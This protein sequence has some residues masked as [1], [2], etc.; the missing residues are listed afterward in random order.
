MAEEQELVQEEEVED[1]E[2][3][4]EAAWDQHEAEATEAVEE[5]AQQESDQVKSN[6]ETD[7][8]PEP[9]SVQGV[10]DPET[11]EQQEET[12]FL[13]QDEPPVSESLDAPP[14][15]L[16]ADARAVWDDTP[17]TMKAAIVARERQAYEG[18]KAATAK[19]KQ[20]EQQAMVAQDMSQALAPH[21]QLLQTMGGPKQG[22]SQ[23]LQTA[24]LLQYG[25][26]EQKAQ[27]TARLISGFDVD[28]DTLADSLSGQAPTPAQQNMQGGMTPQQIQ[29]LVEQQIAARDQQTMASQ[30]DNV[31]NQF[32]AD[33]KNKYYKDVRNEMANL[34]DVA[35]R[36]GQQLSIQDAYEQ[37]CWANPSVRKAQ[38]IEMQRNNASAGAQQ[39]QQRR[40]A[41]SSISGSPAGASSKEPQTREEALEMAWDQV[42]GRI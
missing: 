13:Q 37:A 36:M 25:T 18:V 7:V 17:E 31:I 38:L 23:L 40:S 42:N 5:P 24:S 29:Q 26:R 35:D 9:E 11:P 34:L 2:A 15:S 6:A 22:V 30:A 16:P 1:R 39:I 12:G 27:A 4:L 28:I 19:Y 20:Y 21:A 33:P 41:A 10:G 32:A 3:S 14:S 8:A